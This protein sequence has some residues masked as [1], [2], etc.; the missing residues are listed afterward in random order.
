MTGWET[1]DS[2][3][4][5]T[6]SGTFSVQTT[7]K[8]TGAYALQS[9]PTTTAVGYQQ[10]RLA[11]AWVAAASDAVLA[12][13][14]LYVTLYFQYATKPSSGDE[15]LIEFRHASGVKADVRLDLNGNILMYNSAGT[16]LGTS[17][18][19]LTVSTWYRL[20]I[21]CGTSATVGAY[22]VKINGASEISGTGNLNAAQHSGFR[23]GKTTNRNGNTVDYYYDDMIVDDAAYIG[24]GAVELMVPTA[25]G[26]YSAWTAGNGTSSFAEVD[27]V[28]S[29]SATSYIAPVADTNASTFNLE[30]CASAGISGT[31]NAVKF[32][33]VAARV[34]G[35]N[36]SYQARIRNGSTDVDS[37]SLTATSSYGART[38]LI[39]T[40]PNGAIA[41]TTS[42]LDSTEIGVEN[43][44]ASN[45]TRVT[46]TVLQVHFTASGGGDT[47][48]VLIGGDLFNGAT[49]FG[50][51]IQ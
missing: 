17:S 31:I 41:W 2:Q 13:D 6:T 48:A 33:V 43:V 3:E 39:A 9:N 18:S 40:D 20:D 27:E 12:H 32:Q 24:A 35:T 22:E 19:V 46:Q 4:V 50:R 47:N 10:W 36:T 51:L 49:L 7:T 42:G 44:D 34:G 1:G 28:P 45:I 26:T 30:S 8:R 38:S 23:V 25:T 37:S 11:N 21:K 14:T 15:P 5:V 29:D 16:L